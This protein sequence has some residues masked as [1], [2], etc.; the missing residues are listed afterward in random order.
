MMRPLDPA[1]FLNAETYART[2]LPVEYASTL[3]PDAYTMA[4]FYA[5]EQERVF[6]NSWVPVCVTDEVRT[7]GEFKGCGGGGA[8]H[9]CDA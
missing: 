4:E 6:A 3:I 2:R 8:F 9:N 5:L 7:P 1:Q